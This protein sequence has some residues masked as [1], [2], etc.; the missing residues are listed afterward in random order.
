[1]LGRINIFWAGAGGFLALFCT[2][3][4]IAYN[5]SRAPLWLGGPLAYGGMFV[6]LVLGLSIAAFL[7]I[8]EPREATAGGDAGGS[9][10]AS[11]DDVGD[12]EDTD[13]ADDHGGGHHSHGGHHEA[14]HDVGDAG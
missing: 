14:G 1:M 5:L 8:E 6:G 3:E 9:D 2:N 10:G 4:I 12:E 11:D 7:G 13:D